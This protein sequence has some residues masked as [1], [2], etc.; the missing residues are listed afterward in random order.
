MRT[1][2][3]RA[4][5]HELRTSGTEVPLLS[6]HRLVQEYDRTVARLSQRAESS[7]IERAADRWLERIMHAAIQEI[8]L[9]GCIT[10]G[11]YTAFVEALNCIDEP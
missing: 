9:R 1:Q 8:R 7:V 2:K 5:L 4:V 3:F 11:A 6:L 10:A